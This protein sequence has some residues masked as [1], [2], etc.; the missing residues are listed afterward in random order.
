[1]KMRL[2]AHGVE[3]SGELKDF[4]HRRIDFS[5]GRLAG[6]IKSLTVRL[7]DINGPRGGVDKCCDI[8]IDAGFR[9]VVIVREQQATIQAAVAL[10]V[11]RAERAVQ[12]QLRLGDPLSERSRALRPSPSFGD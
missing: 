7:A 11:D 9:Q 4:V 10:A 2:T 5:L 6:R 8:R 12:R 1:M 3:L